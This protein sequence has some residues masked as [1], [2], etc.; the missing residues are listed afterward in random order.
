MQCDTCDS[1]RMVCIRQIA[2]G[3]VYQHEKR[4]TKIYPDCLV[5]DYSW[6]SSVYDASHLWAADS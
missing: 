6:N 4:N 1:K 2:S 3:I 5:H